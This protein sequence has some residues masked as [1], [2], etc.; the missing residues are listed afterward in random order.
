MKKGFSLVPYTRLARATLKNTKMNKNALSLAQDQSTFSDP[1]QETVYLFGRSARLQRI[2]TGIP[3]RM[4][5]VTSPVALLPPR[6]LFIIYSL[7]CLSALSL[8]CRFKL[9]LVRV[10]CG[11]F[12]SRMRMDR[13]I[14]FRD[15]VYLGVRCS[16][17]T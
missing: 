12:C 15:W 9:T 5:S 3:H 13:E 6:N 14:T 8:S 2:G 10:R 1:L 11:H 16:S 7:S 17:T 4:P